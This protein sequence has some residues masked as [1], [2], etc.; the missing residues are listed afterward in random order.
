MGVFGVLGEPG[1]WWNPLIDWMPKMFG[2][3]GDTGEAGDRGDLRVK[4]CELLDSNSAFSKMMVF[5]FLSLFF[6]EVMGLLSSSSVY[7][8]SF[9]GEL[10]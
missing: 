4:T 5:S 10:L 6:I 7:T 1:S 9:L 8:C 2:Y 3:Q